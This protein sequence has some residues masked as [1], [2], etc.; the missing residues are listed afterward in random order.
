MIKKDKDWIVWIAF[1][2]IPLA[3]AYCMGNRLKNGDFIFET[4][5]V[6]TFKTLILLMVIGASLAFLAGSRLTNNN[7]WG[8]AVP[9]DRLPDFQILTT[10]KILGQDLFII[11][12][13][14]A[15]DTEEKIFN[16]DD[17]VKGRELLK[18][19]EDSIFAGGVVFAPPPEIKS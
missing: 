1:A 3:A 2:I 16:L 4:G 6:D 12:P 7:K 14:G 5:A 13:K 10:V 11:K 19:G 8:K 18:E 9:S 15:E 17:K